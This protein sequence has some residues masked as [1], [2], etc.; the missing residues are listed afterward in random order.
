MCRGTDRWGLV[1]HKFGEQVRQ[2]GPEKTLRYAIVEARH[3]RFLERLEAQGISLRWLVN[4]E[5][6]A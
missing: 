5:C 4:N 6:E 3:A 1:Q 2:T